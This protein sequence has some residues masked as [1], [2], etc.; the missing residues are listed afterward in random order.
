MADADRFPPLPLAAWE[1]SKT[2]L[3]LFLQI[4]G[5]VRMAL[6]PKL[7]H[8]WHL[9]LY[10]APRGLTTG[11]IPL[12]DR[13][14]RID[15]DLRD[16]F[17]AL[18]DSD[19]RLERF[20]IPGLTVG[21][22]YRHFFDA[23]AVLGVEA[24][25]KAVPYD[26][27]SKIPFAEDETHGAYDP[28]YIE[29]FSRTLNGVAGVFEQFRGRFLGK[30]TPVHLFWHSFDL[31][32]T[33]FSGKAGPPMEGGTQAD[34][35]AYSHEVISVGFWAGDDN[36]REPAFYAYA[37][38]E[39]D[40]LAN[41]RLT[42]SAARWVEQRGSHLALLPYEAARTDADPTATLLGFLEGAYQGAAALAGWPVKE[43]T[44]GA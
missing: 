12:A 37:Y 8:W 11:T 43:L 42:P 26:H 44:R 3:H 15:L 31:A 25:I 27:K 29:R 1:D 33:R 34:R 2:T 28:I 41:A 36:V 10:P 32:L 5:K 16:H 24:A 20:D 4:V 39:P 22:F 30:S 14:L 13:D 17:V 19:G 21:G 40:G 18:S 38:P 6:H 23:L 9:T 7:N 35:E